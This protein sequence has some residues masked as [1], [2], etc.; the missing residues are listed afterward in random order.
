METKIRPS[1]WAKEIGIGLI[2]FTVILIPFINKLESNPFHPDESH[3][4]HTVKYFKLFFI[5][6]DFHN[7]QWM[8]YFA[9]DQPPVGRYIIGLALVIPGY[10]KN[11]EK[12]SKMSVWDFSK[13]YSWNESHGALPPKDVLYVARLPMA[14]LG[15]LTCFLM[16]WVAKPIFSR[17]AGIIAALLLAYNPLMLR[18]SQRAMPDAAL[19]FFLAANVVLTTYFY[20]SLVEQKLHRTL[21]FAAFIGITIALAAGTKLNGGIAGII[22]A[23][24][25]TVLILIKITPYGF[26]GNNLKDVI[27]RLRTDREVKIILGSL[28]ISGLIAALVFTALNPYLYHRPLKGSVKMVQHRMSVVKEQQQTYSAITTVRQKIELVV[29][30]T[31][32]D[33]N[34]V[35]L[36]YFLKI[37]LDMGLFLLGLALLFYTEAKYLFCNHK[38]SSKSIVIA[39]ISIT[40]V[41]TTA[42]I[43]L[44]WNRYYLPVLPCVAMMAGYGTDRIL[45]KCWRLANRKRN[46]EVRQSQ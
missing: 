17:R 15:A 34:Y 43:P 1:N 2:L 11:L 16:Y 31:L 19:I 37:P 24:F 41:G 12:S 23:V 10:G 13:D 35:T 25:C 7:D 33:K 29:R 9:Y 46:F 14:I 18:C 30:R 3:W 45:N 20:S 40:F 5:D 6:R 27:G 21:V 8:E 22:F 38:L 32:I 36:G 42:W 28:I 39:W 26:P 4:I 44:D